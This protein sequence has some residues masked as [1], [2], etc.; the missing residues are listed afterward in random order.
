MGD[1][2]EMFDPYKK[3][4]GVEEKLLKT[5]KKKRKFRAM[6]CQEFCFKHEYCENCPEYNDD[7]RSCS[8]LMR[9][10]DCTAPYK[11]TDGK[12]ILVE[13]KE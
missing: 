4:Q 9:E 7:T 8:R 12:Y 13:V 11:T 3:L 5:S 10:S 6:I 2:R 1:M